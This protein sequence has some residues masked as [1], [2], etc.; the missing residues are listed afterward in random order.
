[1]AAALSSVVTVDVGA[2]DRVEGVECGLVVDGDV[3]QL[4]DAIDEL[5]EYFA[6]CEL[7]GAAGYR[8]AEES[9]SWSAIAE[10]F[11][12]LYVEISRDQRLAA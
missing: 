8:A 2:S 4:A 10:R 12:A 7:M 9:F 11:E 6:L 3:G 5:L 1:M